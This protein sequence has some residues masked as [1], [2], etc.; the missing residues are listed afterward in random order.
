MRVILNLDT[1]EDYI[2]PGMSV[3]MGFSEEMIEIN[4]F[5]PLTAKINEV[6]TN[7][8]LN[9]LME[10]ILEENIAYR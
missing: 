7:Q 3:G 6:L 4:L 9:E 5:L 1:G 8:K 10:N 2:N